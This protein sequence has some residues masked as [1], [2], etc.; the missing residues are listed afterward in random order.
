MNKRKKKVY[1]YLL[2]IL[3]LTIG[4]ALLSTTLKI[5]G[6]AGI[7]KNTWNI[8]WDDESVVVTPNSVAGNTPTVDGPN[9]NTVDD[10]FNYDP[11]HKQPIH[12]RLFSLI[13]SIILV[14]IIQGFTVLL[15]IRLIIR[16]YCFSIALIKSLRSSAPN[17]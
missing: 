4:F 10:L 1:L 8:H 6:V 14:S 17:K 12:E 11:S 9:D 7:N 16:G 3:G 13:P 15:S 2:I 5:N